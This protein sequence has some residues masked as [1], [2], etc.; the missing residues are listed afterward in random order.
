MLGERTEPVP[1]SNP[2][3]QLPSKGI[4]LLQLSYLLSSFVLFEQSK[5]DRQLEERTRFDL[6]VGE[7]V[8]LAE[9]T[10][11]KWPWGKVRVEFRRFCEA[12]SS[13]SSR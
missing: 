7:L 8:E 12:A 13:L 2:D 3:R 11:A 4:F 1:T 5:N 6:S 9:A 10:F